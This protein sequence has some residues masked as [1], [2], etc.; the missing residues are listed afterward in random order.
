MSLDEGIDVQALNTGVSEDSLRIVSSSPIGNEQISDE[1]LRPH[2]LDGFI[3]QP[4]LKAQLQLFW[5]LQDC[6]MFLQ[7]TCCLQVLLGLE[8]QH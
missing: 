2:A 5:M 4:L 1:E 6:V 8:K 3:G 7:I